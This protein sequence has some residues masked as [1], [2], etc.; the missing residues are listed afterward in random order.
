MDALLITS[1]CNIGLLSSGTCF[2]TRY[3]KS[4]DGSNVI[5]CIMDLVIDYSRGDEV[6]SKIRSG[7]R[8]TAIGFKISQAI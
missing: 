2:L 4:L 6:R 5:N 3:R 7:L 8:A 1:P